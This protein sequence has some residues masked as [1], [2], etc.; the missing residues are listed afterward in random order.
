MMQ[1]GQS[2][3]LPLGKKINMKIQQV[4]TNNHT[5]LKSYLP[6]FLIRS[7]RIATKQDLTVVH[8]DSEYPDQNARMHR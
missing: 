6:P 8:A 5:Q 7:I 3:N 4:F 1:V 2:F